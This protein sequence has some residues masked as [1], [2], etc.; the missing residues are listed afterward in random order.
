MLEINQML[1]SGLFKVEFSL[2]GIS[3]LSYYFVSISTLEVCVF[4]WTCAFSL[5][6][7]SKN[8]LTSQKIHTCTLLGFK[9]KSI[10]IVLYICISCY[11]Y[12]KLAD[13]CIYT[14]T[15]GRA[16]S[17]YISIHYMFFAFFECMYYPFPFK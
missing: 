12:L 14:H 5:N 7:F 3:C 1:I 15:H 8:Y 2:E 11:S 17:L 4:S 16:E 10:A 6:N 13:I 9:V